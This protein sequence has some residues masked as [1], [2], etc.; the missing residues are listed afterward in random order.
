M[1]YAEFF[2]GVIWGWAM[3]RPLFGATGSVEMRDER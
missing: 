1:E 3:L 2:F